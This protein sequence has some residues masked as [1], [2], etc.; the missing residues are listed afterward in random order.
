MIKSPARLV[1]VICS[2]PSQQLE[3]GYYQTDTIQ[4][5]EI[6]DIIKD[7]CY[8]SVISSPVSSMTSF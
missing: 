8:H 4:P 5:D 1:Y 6:E 2:N 3:D 7:C